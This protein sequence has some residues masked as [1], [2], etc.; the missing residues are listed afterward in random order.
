MTFYK[1]LTI[2]NKKLLI[3]TIHESLNDPQQINQTINRYARPVILLNT[4]FTGKT[5]MPSRVMG[6]RTFFSYF[7]LKIEKLSTDRNG[8]KF[9][10]I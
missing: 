8:F 1:L 10:N 5:L 9:I 3:F 4:R 2:V 7:L 6:F